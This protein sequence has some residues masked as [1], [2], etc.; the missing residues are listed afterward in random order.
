M[1]LGVQVGCTCL[2]AGL[3][4]LAFPPFEVRTL[5]WIALTP[6]LIALRSSRLRTAVLLAVLWSL[7]MSYGITSWLIDAVAVYYQQPLIYGIA[8]LAATTL[9]GATVEYVGFATAYV[10]AARR[11]PLLTVPIAAAAWAACE[12]C[13]TRIGIGNPWGMLG[14]SQAGFTVAGASSWRE[15][16]AY[17]I[18]QIADVG[19]VYAISFVLMSCSAMAAE[20]LTARS[21]RAANASAAWGVAT[22]AAAIV[23]G[24]FR[25]GAGAPVVEAETRVAIIQPNLD[26]GTQWDESYYGANLDTYLSLTRAAI[27]TDQTEVVFWPENAMTFFVDQEPLYRAAIASVTKATGAE[28]V[29]GAPRYE[30]IDSPI[31]FNSA[32]SLTP[33]GAISGR[34]DKRRLLPFAEYFPLSTIDFLNRSFARVRTFTP[35]KPI[36]PITTRAGVAG[37]IICN[38]AM[39]PE[40]TV[41]RIREG[42]EYLVNLSNDSWVPDLRFTEHQLQIATLR[43]LEHRRWLVR[44]SSSGPSAI[45]D[46]L[47]RIV[48]RSGSMSR[49]TVAGAIGRSTQE[50]FYARHGDLFAWSCLAATLAALMAAVLPR[51]RRS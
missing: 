36:E 31:Y 47:G 30:A 18:A 51:R 7:L 1:R 46:P 25:L 23:Y 12:L 5:A 20:L 37:L 43:A 34:Y 41:A 16:P 40:D 21:R 15:G 2:S 10:V 50:T 42:A 9:F 13:R 32:F 17:I 26:L 6:L 19:G 8:M 22:I 4:V 11:F 35:G 28:L 29:A 27:R 3:F 49:A 14:Y 48:T 33:D 44:A 38:E 45:V 39:Y 24:M